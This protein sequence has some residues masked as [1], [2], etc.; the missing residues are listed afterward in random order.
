MSDLCRSSESSLTAYPR[1]PDDDDDF[2]NGDDDN[3]DDRNDGG[4]EDNQST[5]MTMNDCDNDG[6]NDGDNDADDDE[7][8]DYDDDDND[9]LE[10]FC[11]QMKSANSSVR[12]AMASSPGK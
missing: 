2:D 9:V 4:E 3:D 5:A 7:D 11:T 10:K 8:D 12:L 6:D 1:C